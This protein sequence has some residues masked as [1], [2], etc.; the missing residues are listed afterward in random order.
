[1]AI[2]ISAMYASKKLEFLQPSQSGRFDS[3]FVLAANRTIGELNIIAG[4][5]LS[6]IS[7]LE[8]NFDNAIGNDIES[9]ISDGITFHLARLGFSSERINRTVAERDW[10][11]ARGL[12]IVSIVKAKD[13]AEDDIAMLGA[14]DPTE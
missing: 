10:A 5:G 7:S 9:V 13:I 12:Y 8:G 3:A 11:D 1:M 6:L 2:S 4:Q 14:L